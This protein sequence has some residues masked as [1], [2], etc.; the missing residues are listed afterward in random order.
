MSDSNGYIYDPD[1]ID[2]E[3]LAYI[4]ELK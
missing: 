1:G 2:A 4:M 3:K